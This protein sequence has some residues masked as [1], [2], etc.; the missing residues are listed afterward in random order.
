MKRIFFVFVIFFL[1]VLLLQNVYAHFYIIYPQDQGA[2]TLLERTKHDDSGD[3]NELYPDDHHYFIAVSNIGRRY[4]GVHVEREIKPSDTEKVESIDNGQDDRIILPGVSAVSPEVLLYLC[5]SLSNYINYLQGY[6]YPDEWD[7]NYYRAEIR[8]YLLPVPKGLPPGT[9]VT[10]TVHVVGP[11]PGLIPDDLENHEKLGPL[12]S[13]A[14]YHTYFY[15]FAL[16]LIQLIIPTP[17]ND[18]VLS[19]IFFDYIAWIE[20]S[21][22]IKILWL[23]NRIGEIFFETLKWMGDSRLIEQQVKLAKGE[24]WVNNVLLPIKQKL[25]AVDL[26]QAFADVYS[27]GTWW[28]TFYI[29]ISIPKIDEIVPDTGNAGDIVTIRGSGFDP[30]F[31]ENNYVYF[32][33]VNNYPAVRADITAVPSEVEIRVKVPEN[34]YPGPVQ[35]D[36]DGLLSN[37]INFSDDFRATLNITAPKNGATLEGLTTL[38]AEIIDPPAYFPE[39]PA[40][41]RLYIDDLQVGTESQVQS[42]EFTYTLDVESLTPGLHTARVEVEFPGHTISDSILF[43]KETQGVMDLSAFNRVRVVFNTVNPYKINKGETLYDDRATSL[44]DWGHKGSFDGDKYSA[45]WT[46]FPDTGPGNVKTTLDIDISFNSDH[47]MITDLEYKFV[48]DDLDEDSVY[49]LEEYFRAIYIP[50]HDPKADTVI[51]KL[52]KDSVCENITGYYNYQ[53]KNE[54]YER[55]EEKGTCDQDTFLEVTFYKN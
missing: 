8:S 5:S 6:K 10:F 16:P 9:K 42:N 54:T 17:I 36:V 14:V 35:V 2:T 20:R 29:E 51:F 18:E 7:E 26:I 27:T 23:Q 49:Y 19:T 11:G 1:N 37:M 3:V 39:N 30:Y 40:T 12:I 13:D 31:P 44:I 32:S 34:S 46:N 24:A 55:M 47:D 52:T 21:K 50:V 43:Y 22:E 53:R 4:V 38:V 45:H 15:I 33:S 48:E 25:V 41:K 28:D